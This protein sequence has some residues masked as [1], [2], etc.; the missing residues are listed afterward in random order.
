MPYPTCNLLLSLKYLFY[1]PFPGSLFLSSF[2]VNW[3]SVYRKNLSHDFLY[4]LK[5]K[6]LYFF[7]SRTPSK[8][9]NTI[10]CWMG[11]FN[12][13][14]NCLK[15]KGRVKSEE[16]K[17][18]RTGVILIM[19]THI[20]ASTYLSDYYSS[21]PFHNTLHGPIKHRD[22]NLEFINSF[23]SFPLKYFVCYPNELDFSK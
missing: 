7:S 15:R 9:I 18:L 19:A 21:F 11:E 6:E 8:K 5:L 20:L 17:I 2:I 16:V 12:K 23:F 1:S 14:F 10:S 22:K 4:N 3:F 13:W